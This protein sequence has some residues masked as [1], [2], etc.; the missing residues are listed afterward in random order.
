MKYLKLKCPICPHGC[1]LD[2]QE[3]GFC[4]A[5]RHVDDRIISINY[6]KITSMALDPIEKKPLARFLP[7]SRVLSVGSFGCNLRCGFCQNS[8][9]SMCGEAEVGMV[10]VAPDALAERAA[11]LVP[12][13]NIG[14]AFTYNEPFIGFEYLKDSM[15]EVKKRGLRNVLVTNG[16]ICEEPLLTLLPDIDVMNIDLK[17]FSETFYKKLKGDLETV[18]NTIRQAQTACHVEVTTLIIPDENDKEEETA[19]IARWLASMNPEIPYHIS[20]FFPQ[21]QYQDKPATDVRKIYRLAEIA[22]RHLKYVYTGNC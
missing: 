14:V 10:Y 18:K 5:R 2:R 21:Y 13:G 15:R 16:Y 7:G 17:G 1:L 9:I 19:A 8:S 20:R 11:D 4:R 6:G 12:Q 22:R 3:T